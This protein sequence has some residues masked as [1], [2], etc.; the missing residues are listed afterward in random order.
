MQERETAVRVRLAKTAGFC[1]GVR[2]AMDIT[3]KSI[4]RHGRGLLTFGPLIHNPQV[5]DLLKGKG[6]EIFQSRGSVKSNQPVIIR[7]HGIPPYEREAL[8]ELG[9]TIIDAT[10]PRVLNVQSIIRRHACGGGFTVIVGDANHPEVIGL[11]GYA[12]NG[13][14]VV[15]TREDVEKI[16]TGKKL[17]VVAQT[18]QNEAKYAQIASEIRQRFPETQIYQTICDSTQK[19]QDEAVRMA[20]SVDAM[21][22]VGGEN[23]AN[24]ARL[25]ELVRETGKPVLQV[26]TDDDIDPSWLRNTEVV[27]ITAGASTPNWIIQ[28]VVRKVEDIVPPGG[29]ATVL[30]RIRQALNFLVE[31]DL[32]GAFAA[33]SLSYMATKLQNLPF[34][35]GYFVIAMAYVYSM[36]IWNRFTDAEAGRLNDPIRAEFYEKHGST[37]RV[38]GIVSM[39]FALTASVILGYPLFLFLLAACIGGVTYSFSFIP[40]GRL[41]Q[42]R[43]RRLKD[44]PGSKTVFIA[45]AWA[46]VATLTAPLSTSFEMNLNLVATF[47]VVAALVLIRSA[48]FDLKDIQGDLIVGNETIPIVLGKRNSQRLLILLLTMVGASFFLLPIVGILP[49]LSYGLI[50]GIAYIGYCLRLVFRREFVRSDQLEIL[51]DG[52]LILQGLIVLAWGLLGLP[53]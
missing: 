3:L 17:C 1:M 25:T 18:T 35:L 19:R 47:L 9:S 50:A 11:M 36:H 42:M 22:V 39:V 29:T 10:C 38:V 15:S 6:V 21:I 5:L 45:L 20:E 49:P 30:F 43:Y 46:G 26:E 44:I 2:R 53:Q 23:S 14:T 12:G 4:A 24:T 48:T 27:G 41:M 13:G 32:Y 40:S 7:A 37:L 34:R 51:I 31:S 8:S 52:G 33:G 16:P 28:R